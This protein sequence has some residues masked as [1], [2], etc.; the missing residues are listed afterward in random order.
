MAEFKREERY[1]VIKRKHL[2]LSTEGR[3]RGVLYDLDISTV[4]CVVVEEDWHP[5]Y[6]ETWKNVQ[7]LAE[8]KPSIGEERDSLQ[9]QLSELTSLVKEWICEKCNYVYPGPPQDGFKCVICPRCSGHTMPRPVYDRR[10]LE[11]QLSEARAQREKFQN[12]FLLAMNYIGLAPDA[13]EFDE[14]RLNAWIELQNS[15]ANYE[16]AHLRQQGKE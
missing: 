12:L 10:R 11:S 9:S 16:A 7:R 13:Q 4:E 14:D 6:Q 5:I 1:I 3:L 15:G 8:G 2:D